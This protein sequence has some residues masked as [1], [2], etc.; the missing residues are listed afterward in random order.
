ML[1]GDF[2]R[3]QLKSDED[4]EDLL[5]A[6]R[7]TL[8]WSV[9]DV[10][11]RVEV[12]VQRLNDAN[13]TAEINVRVRDQSYKPFDNASVAIEVQTPDGKAIELTGEPSKTEPGL[14][15]AKFVSSRPG[16]Y[17][18]VVQAAAEDGSEIE[19]RETGWVSEPDTEEFQSLEPNREFLEILAQRSGGEVVELDRLDSFVKSLEHR[20]VPI[21]E[22]SSL[23]WWHRWTIFAIAI[24][25]L[26]SEWGIRRW[27]GLP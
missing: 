24:G 15:L 11:R 23:P 9:A 25:L 4:N 8:R 6:W 22:T 19:Q 5:K 26:V 10:P 21:T 18:A 7:Q 16:A 2:W 14:Y 27:K 20:E 1:I 12:A 3:W 13:R 17:R